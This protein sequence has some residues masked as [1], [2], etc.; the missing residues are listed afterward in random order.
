MRVRYEVRQLVRSVHKRWLET[1][2]EAP[3]E[4]VMESEFRRLHA[5]HPGE[6]FELV[7]VAQDERCLLHV[8]QRDDGPSEIV[9]PRDHEASCPCGDPNCLSL[10]VEV[11]AAM[12]MTSNAS[13]TRRQVWEI[14]QAAKIARNNQGVLA[15]RVRALVAQAGLPDECVDL[16]I[17]LVNDLKRGPSLVDSTVARHVAEEAHGKRYGIDWVYHDDSRGI[18]SEREL[19]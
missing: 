5:E 10:N 19:A 9:V 13:L 18:L 3:G 15:D 1:V 17:E 4:R 16:L 11:S 7:R 8:L 12:A 6:Y 14:L 2:A